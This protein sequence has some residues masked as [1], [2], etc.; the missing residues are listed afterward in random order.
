MRGQ[1]RAGCRGACTSILLTRVVA[2]IVF[3]AI[4]LVPGDPAA[5]LLSRGGPAPDPAA[6]AELRGQFGLDWRMLVQYADSLRRLVAGDLGRSSQDD[7]P[8]AGRS[9]AAGRAR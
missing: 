7:S 1:Q 4:R 6:V 9:H 8:V 5:P 3:P 2:G